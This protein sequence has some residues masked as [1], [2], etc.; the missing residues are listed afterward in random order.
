MNELVSVCIPVYNTENYLCDCIESLTKQSYSNIELLFNDNGSTD[1]SLAILQKYAHLDN[2][3]KIYS[4]TN[5]GPAGARNILINNSKGRYILFV[6][7]DDVVANDYV[8]DFINSIKSNAISICG[9]SIDYINDSNSVETNFGDICNGTLSDKVFYLDKLGLLYSPCNKLYDR[10]IIDQYNIMFNE[11]L[12]N[13]EDLDFNV[14]YLKY[15]NDI[16]IVPKSN[17][18]Y[19]K[20]DKISDVNSFRKNIKEVVLNGIKLKNELYNYF[21][22]E[23]KENQLVLLSSNVDVL[24]YGLINTITYFRYREQKEVLDIISFIFEEANNLEYVDCFVP[25]NLFQKIFMF[26]YKT[27][28][29]YLTFIIY[30]LLLFIRHR[31]KKIYGFIRKYCLNN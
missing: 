21:C 26:C 7:S 2:R 13:C 27:K 15:I 11:S 5:S 9:M 20:Y 12:C 30:K 1:N 8:L 23:E 10:L 29:K 18:Y 17:Y 19:R 31:F 4:T 22:L 24:N 25:K 6:D 16:V 3:I 14:K 28:S